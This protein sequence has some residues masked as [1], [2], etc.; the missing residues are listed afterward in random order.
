MSDLA[1][2]K[3]IPCE[4][5]TSC[6]P[7][8]KAQELIIKTPGWSINDN[9]LTKHYD[10]EDF[11]SALAFVN[12]VGEIA[13]TEGHHPDIC[14]TWGKVDITLFTHA[15]NGLTENDFIMA[16]KINEISR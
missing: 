8:A 11:K 2:K 10:F 15:A 7:D 5:G 1:A 3:C 4:E 9:H 14:F 13:E 12:K 6:L 16:A